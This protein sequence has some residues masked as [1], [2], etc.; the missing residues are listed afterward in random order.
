MPVFQWEMAQPR[1]RISIL[2]AFIPKTGGTAL[3][4]YVRE[5]GFKVYFHN[6]NNPIIGLVKCPTQHFHYDM[7][8]QCFNLEQFSYSFC[9]VRNPLD[10][11]KSDYVWLFRN[12][13][14]K[15]RLPS[16]DEF[17]DRAFREYAK[18]PFVF[19]NH[20]RPQHQ[21]VGEH[22]R[23]VFKYE[24]GL[25][26][27]CAQVFQ[28]SGLKVRGDIAIKNANSSEEYLGKDRSSGSIEVASSTR[29]KV[30]RFYERDYEQ[31]GYE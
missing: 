26:T 7:L 29:D 24:D 10:R 1:R 15:S 30:Y 16:F 8:D 28:D 31:F 11:L 22:I 17:A 21:F 5:L 6:E 12:Q 9:V 3:I 20:I 27:I 19:D 23:R 25:N 18:N 13:R 14:D 4:N 2:H